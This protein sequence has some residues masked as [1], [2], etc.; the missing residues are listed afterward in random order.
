VASRRPPEPSPDPTQ[1]GPILPLE[2]TSRTYSNLP[3]GD[4]QPGQQAWFSSHGIDPRDH[5]AIRDVL[6]RSH[7]AHRLPFDALSRALARQSG[8]EAY[9]RWHDEIVAS[10]AE[11]GP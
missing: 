3:Y 9:R 2:L 4:F 10:A 5:A 6:S 1:D 11:D 8:L 7:A